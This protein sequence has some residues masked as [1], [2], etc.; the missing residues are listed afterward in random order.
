[1]LNSIF[2]G[3]FF[4]ELGCCK[5]EGESVKMTEFE[6]EVEKNSKEEVGV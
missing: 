2:L 1:M 6:N 3:V 4:I 5:F